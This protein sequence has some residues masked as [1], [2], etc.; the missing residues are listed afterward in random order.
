MSKNPYAHTYICDECSFSFQVYAPG[1]RKKNAYYC[2][3]CGENFWVRRYYPET[4]TKNKGKK[5]IIKWS[6]EELSLLDKVK[7]KELAPYQ[8]AIM[9]GRSVNSVRKKLMRV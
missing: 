9:T 5:I 1:T 8:V 6:E 3:S 4:T 7:A 2:P